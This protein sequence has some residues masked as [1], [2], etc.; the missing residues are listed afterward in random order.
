MEDAKRLILLAVMS[1]V[2]SCLSLHAQPQE[3]TTALLGPDLVEIVALDTTIRLDIRYATS[4]NFMGRPMY[5]QARAFLQRPAA[6]AVVRAHRKLLPLGLGLLIYDG[7]RPWSVTKDFWDATPADK[8]EFV[9][10]PAKGSRHNRGCAVDVTLYDRST[11]L[12]VPMPSAYDDFSERAGPYYPG[13]TDRERQ[14]RFILR[15][16]MESEGFAVEKSEWWHYDHA[17]W[18]RYR[19]LNVPFEAI[20]AGTDR[21]SRE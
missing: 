2:A 14:M 4:N 17:E 7:Y 11:G 10:D 1:S 21:P 13:G 16:V 18:K 19:I 15:T 8:K 6:E 9:A 3:D 12:E 20:P 5:S